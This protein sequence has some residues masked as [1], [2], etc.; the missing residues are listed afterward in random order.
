MSHF[1]SEIL[2]VQHFAKAIGRH[3]DLENCQKQ[4]YLKHE[5]SFNDFDKSM[6]RFIFQV[7]GL[8]GF[9]AFL[10]TSNW[11]VW[12]ADLIKGALWALRK[13]HLSLFSFMF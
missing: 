1:S 7:K 13:G 9:A 12:I 6:S 4:Q 5:F 10:M 8:K 11:M 3:Q 2:S